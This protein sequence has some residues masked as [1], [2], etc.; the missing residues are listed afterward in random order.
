[1]RF[2]I[3]GAG[4]IGGT[5]GGRLFEAGHD[6]TLIARGAHLDALRS[7]GLTVVS[8][9]RTVTLPVPAVG[10]PAEAGLAPGD[11]VILAVKSQATLDAVASLDVAAPPGVAVA[12]AQNGVEN[13]RVV[14]RRFP[15]TYAVNV[16]LPSL[17][18][19]PGVVVPYGSPVNGILDVGRY[20]SGVD[21][22]AQGL[23]SALVT[24][25][26]ASEAR[27]DILR[28]K[29]SKLLDNLRN[30]IDAVCGGGPEPGDDTGEAGAADESAA[31]EELAALV[32]AEGKAVLAAAGIDVVPAGVDRARRGTLLTA[33]PPVPGAP[34]RSS[35]WQSLTK[36]A[37]SVE[38]D[39][40]TGEVVLLGRLHG[41][42]TPANALL[43]RLATEL[44]AEGRPPGSVR[45]SEVLARLG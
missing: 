9:D 37:G 21:E 40:L 42:A 45:A 12:C 38:T 1:M 27:P 41:V 13:E 8:A 7:R 2:V 33:G 43:Q 14:L 20:P 17:H 32:R 28:W 24:A 34:R 19:E 6:V 29:Y 4:A 15:A 5:I 11:V 31:V 35:T 30:A 18:L 23:S 3:H 10:S 22:T 39:Y 44:A 16:M 26:F 25:G 36:G